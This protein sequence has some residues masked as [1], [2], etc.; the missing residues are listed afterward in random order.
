M[1]G[2]VV[3]APG[4]AVLCGEYAVLAGAPAICMAIDRR[5]SVR[6]EDAEEQHG[7]VTTR[8]YADGTWRFVPGADGEL[9]WLDP[10]PD[11]GL[12]I[13]EAA[14]RQSR[15]DA[16]AAITIDTGHFRDR[17]SGQ[18]LGLGSSA[19]ACTALLA[20]LTCHRGDALPD[21]REFVDLH[22]D[23]QGRR[24]SGVDVAASVHGGLLAFRM[25]DAETVPLDWPTGL[26]YRYLWSG[27]A[28]DTVARL[29]GFD[30]RKAHGATLRALI[31]AAEAVAHE[32]AT[33][34]PAELLKL[35]AEY[36]RALRRFGIDHGL[37]IFDA[38]H[39]VVADHA[40][41]AG[42]V[43]KPCGAGGGDIGIVLGVD[44]GAIDA[45]CSQMMKFE[46]SRLD[47]RLDRCGIEVSTGG[48]T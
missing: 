43:Y 41:D 16:A 48:D 28:A 47:L 19:A 29:K 30:H 40:Q 17:N 46:F 32:W 35:I 3:T 2:T 18:K 9:W 37:G 8:G 39:D 44:A 45:F 14:W 4:K 34:S 11:G 27:K 7:R 20:A 23:V 33:A 1:S 38:G 26:E 6:V 10:L 36:G 25:A 15:A 5:A 22:R 13:V 24:G 21:T 12:P 42:M 31:E